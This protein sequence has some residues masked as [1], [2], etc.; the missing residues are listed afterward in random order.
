MRHVA[1]LVLVSL[2]G[3]FYI[4][5]EDEDSRLA[6]LDSA[7]TGAPPPF[8]IRDFTPTVVSACTD[9]FVFLVEGEIDGGYG[10]AEF[11]TLVSWDEEP[12]EPAGSATADTAF[13]GRARVAF[14][15]S[16]PQPDATDCAGDW[17]EHSLVVGLSGPAE[18]QAPVVDPIR[19]VVDRAPSVMSFSLVDAGNV[20]TPFDDV[21]P[22]TTPVG[23]FR[24]TE[25]P[26]LAIGL[27]LPFVAAGGAADYTVDVWSCPDGIVPSDETAASCIVASA[28]EATIAVDGDLVVV[29]ASGVF[30]PA[31]CADT[32]K[33]HL[34]VRVAGDPCSDGAFL[35]LGDARFAAPDCDADGVDAPADCDDED[36]DVGT[37]T[38]YFIDA[39]KDGL[40]DLATERD[41]CSPQLGWVTSG[42]DCNDADA[43]IKGPSTWYHDFDQDGLGAVLDTKDACVAP[44]GYVADPSDCDD[45]D[46]LKLGPTSWWPDVDNDGFGDTAAPQSA[47]VAP[48][49]YVGNPDDCDDGRTEVNPD[50]LELCDGV[51]N[52]CNVLIDDSPTNM[53]TFY[54]D[55][56]GDGFGDV[57]STSVAC[58]APPGVWS[59]AAGDC[60]LND[61][62]SY[63]GAPEVCSVVQ[64]AAGTDVNNDCDAL[65]DPLDCGTCVDTTLSAAIGE[66]DVDCGGQCD[67]GCG[68]TQSC[69]VDADCGSAACDGTTHT[70]GVWSVLWQGNGF[71]IDAHVALAP[72]G[73]I[74]LAGSADSSSLE[75]ASGTTLGSAPGGGDI[76]VARY[77]PDGQLRWG[78]RIGTNTRDWLGDVAVDALGNVVVVGSF[79]GAVTVFDGHAV[80][81]KGGLDVVVATLDA[82][83]DTKSIDTFGTP[84]DDYAHGVAFDDFGRTVVAGRSGNGIAE[85][86]FVTTLSAGAVV[87]ATAFTGSG[88]ERV[89]SVARHPSG[90]LLVGGYYGEGTPAGRSSLDV[91]PSAGAS[92]SYTSVLPATAG[93]GFVARLSR[94]DGSVVWLRTVEGYGL[95]EVFEVASLADGDVVFGGWFEQNARVS[96]AAT[97]LTSNGRFDAMAARVT[98]ATGAHVWSKGW[99]SSQNDGVSTISVGAGNRPIVGYWYAGAHDTDPGTPVRNLV[100]YGVNDTALSMFDATNGAWVS[101]AS[102]VDHG[103]QGSDRDTSVALDVATNPVT[104][105]VVVGGSIDGWLDVGDGRKRDTLS[106]PP[107]YM[108][109]YVASLG[110]SNWPSSLPQKDGSDASHA[111]VSCYTLHN[112]HPSLASGAYTIDPN[113]GASTDA[114]PVYCD[115]VTMGGGWTRVASIQGGPVCALDLARGTP[116]DV[117][118][119]VIDAWLP[120]AQAAT[121]PFV[122]REILLYASATRYQAFTSTNAAFTWTNVATGVVNGGAPINT[123]PVRGSRNGAPY[124]DLAGDGVGTSYLLRGIDASGST[125]ALGQGSTWSGSFSQ[126]AC[127]TGVEYAMY[128]GQPTGSWYTA[129]YAYLR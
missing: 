111:A 103:Y 74:V 30:G 53:T 67:L 18:L 129:G 105:Q 54:A 60:E 127:T 95:Q 75:I 109:T 62:L 57:S 28:K 3:C 73:D 69:L 33:G 23:A 37:G 102:Y 13:E 19:V 16:S 70:C 94:V 72:D 86:G 107:I 108:G 122:G 80:S 51:D 71:E 10:G 93:D 61:P 25:W 22:A 27:D 97:V 42:T 118:A 90:D 121:I 101:G 83:G 91:T 110:P 87:R 55:V 5:S 114:F 125:M 76:V 98:G 66:T 21:V 113:G 24:T 52:N 84:G 7:D 119:G 29:A 31:G 47:C 45:K 81:S 115:M 43:G 63:P 116:A 59:E 34:F 1:P 26:S 6:W 104:G 78:R 79:S 128:G 92:S 82:A 15:L 124:V 44:S 20:A 117:V 38:A 100:G 99:G 40:G 126:A 77:S 9:P 41:W 39:D 88:A 64:M 17:C 11:S 12:F 68:N 14:E 123:L 8:S 89:T 46:K 35:A 36:V 85:R 49:F 112:E 50:A 106:T 4:S 48:G 120:P 96:D 58:V 65:L 2:A 56:D 32:D